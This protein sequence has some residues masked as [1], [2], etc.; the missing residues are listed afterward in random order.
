MASTF[1]QLGSKTDLPL[2]RAK[3]DMR[4]VI[5]FMFVIIAALLG[6][7]G[8]RF[9]MQEML[10]Y[11]AALPAL[12]CA[13][14]HAEDSADTKHLRFAK[15]LILGV[16]GMIILQI[17]PLPPFIWQSLPGRETLAEASAL[18]G[19]ADVWRPWS[20]NPERS[21]A[22]ALYIIVPATAFW[23]VA[24]LSAENQIRLI[25][26]ILAVA[27]VHIMVSA[28]QA[29][30]GGDSFYMYQTTH[31]GLPIGIFANRN[32]A[33]IF[34]LLCLILSPAIFA[35]RLSSAPLFRQMLLWGLAIILVAAILA[36]SS[37]AIT[38]LTGLSL[39][40]MALFSVPQKYKKKGVLGVLALAIFG[41][42]A[43]VI[44][45][46]N[47]SLGNL[48]DLGE[49]FEQSDDHR[50][51]F[52][53]EALSTAAHYFPFGSGT[54]TF[55]EAFRSQETLDIVGTHFVNHAHNDYIEMVIENG[56]FGA[57]IIIAAIAVLIPALRYAFRRHNAG[58]LSDLPLLGAWAMLIIGLHSLV[59]Y[60]LR[61][62][63]I[64]T[65]FGA[66]AAIIMS[67]LN[68]RHDNVTS[69]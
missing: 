51:E 40:I 58:K 13:L 48:Q 24:S 2:S 27:A 66:I 59:D 34:F 56:I 49:R 37:R 55:D 60:P 30:S 61:S 22:A 12:Y 23:S 3:P 68:G 31:K 63:A 69:H 1:N 47:N 16:V 44:A 14:I 21:L 10:V 17:I 6:G 19:Q 65:L 39:V 53:P 35:H 54:G 57:L 67:V 45:W 64:A 9:P 42:L 36:T 50:Y 25:F 41:A 28:G 15:M 52:W 4:T 32:H 26:C 62:L 8:S 46:W 5:I 38:V 11:L 29:L 33:A 18:L 43:V 7:G 20:I